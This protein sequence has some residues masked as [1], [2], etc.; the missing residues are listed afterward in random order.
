MFEDKIIIN[1][2]IN[3][4]NIIG[5]INK[6]NKRILISLSVI[7]AVAILAIGGTIA[8][9]SDTEVSTGNT[10]TAGALDIEVDNT[11]H[12]DGMICSL[13]NDK[14]VWAEESSGSSTYPELIGKECNCTWVQKDL[15]GDLFFNFNDIKPGD[16]GEN[17]ISLHATA[18]DAYVCIKV[19]NLTNNENGCTEPE[20]IVDDTCATSEQ[21]QGQGELQNY[22]HLKIWR[23]SGKNDEGGI[24]G[25]A[26]DNIYQEGEPILVQDTVI[27][28]N[29]GSWAL[30]SPQLGALKSGATECIGVA[31]SLPGEVGNI[32]QG[33]SVSA[34]ISFYA[35]QARNNGSFTC[36]R[37][38]K[39]FVQTPTA[40]GQNESNKNSNRPYIAYSIDGQCIDFTFV[41][42]TPYLFLFD[43]QIDNETGHSHDWDT[44]VI[45]EGEC[46]GQL[47]GPAYHQVSTQNSTKYVRV[48]GQ[49]S[50]KVGL[51]EGAEQSWYIDWIPF[52]AQTVTP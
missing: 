27:D 51:R 18:N 2:H 44:I 6:M 3:Y 48:C 32:V 4:I 20:D 52:V 17:T 15:S 28:N 42:P 37:A 11:C 40:S 36:D 31:W 24:I 46:N 26:C 30:Y 21:G 39:V 19:D 22:I 23:D 35:E 8:Y 25:T 34:N 13:N 29:S 50:I 5:W 1:I 7:A 9:F 33:D 47:I 12:Y 16:N 49:N 38:S 41:N 10:F 14:Y 43:Y 45:H